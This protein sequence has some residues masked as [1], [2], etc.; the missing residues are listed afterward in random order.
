MN[1][2]NSA[3][4]DNSINFYSPNGYGNVRTKVGNVVNIHEHIK[5][6]VSMQSESILDEA[7]YNIGETEKSN[8]HVPV[9]RIAVEVNNSVNQKQPITSK[10]RLLPVVVL[11]SVLTL[12]LGVVGVM[13]FDSLSTKNV[14]KSS[15]LPSQKSKSVTASP[16]SFTESNVGSVESFEQNVQIENSNQ[17]QINTSPVDDSSA[18][19]GDNEIDQAKKLL[20][21]LD[22]KP[23]KVTGLTDVKTQSEAGSDISAIRIDNLESLARSASDLAHVMEPKVTSLEEKINLQ[24]AQMESFQKA[25]TQTAQLMVSTQTKLIAVQNE[26]N[27]I[28]R[29]IDI[30]DEHIQSLTDKINGIQPNKNATNNSSIKQNFETKSVSQID[31]SPKPKVVEIAST[32]KIV[33]TQLRVLAVN[34]NRA[35]VKSNTDDKQYVIEAGQSYKNLGSVSS[36]SG[37]ENKVY[38]KFENGT[39]WVIA[40]GVN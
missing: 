1:N 18:V 9:N 20:A 40:A 26:V 2:I 16:T 25:I 32:E 37:S 4:I 34:G 31:S 30:N 29:K 14:S 7:N 15:P 12:S 22:S 24:Q 21:D 33:I 38:G 28:K 27:S 39:D 5:G 23:S 8:A 36:I 10:R 11:G 3:G 6:D 35:V 13:Y 19:S 17:S